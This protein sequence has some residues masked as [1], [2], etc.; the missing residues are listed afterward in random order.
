MSG[1]SFS[2]NLSQGFHGKQFSQ[3]PSVP[4][5]LSDSA[6]P[7]GQEADVSWTHNDPEGDPQDRYQLR[8]RSSVV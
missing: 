6:A 4:T 3:R 7:P 8:W 5:N 2:D 1:F